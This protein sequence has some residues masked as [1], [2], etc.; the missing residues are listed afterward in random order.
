MT[1]RIFIDSFET[2]FADLKRQQMGDKE[3]VL[4]IAKRCKRY[5][6]FEM[7]QPLMNTLLALERD[8]CFRIDTETPSYPWVDLVFPAAN[9]EAS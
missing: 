4:K 5:S 2:D 7:T 1:Y 9:G 3:L 8:G 6:A